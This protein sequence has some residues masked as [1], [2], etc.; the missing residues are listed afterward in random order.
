M[1]IK[2]NCVVSLYDTDVVEKSG[3]TVDSQDSLKNAVSQKHGNLP[4]KI[5]PSIR[6]Q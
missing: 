5:R 1:I 4:K 6:H 3:V 2:V